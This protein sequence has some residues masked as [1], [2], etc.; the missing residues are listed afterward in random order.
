MYF[1]SDF[2]NQINNS[3]ELKSLSGTK[4]YFLEKY[5]QDSSY[6]LAYV[7]TAYFLLLMFFARFEVIQ[8]FVIWG[9]GPTFAILVFLNYFKFPFRIPK[10]VIIYFVFWLWTYPGYLSVTYVDGYFRYFRLI[11]T[12]L[13]FFFCIQ[14]VLIRTGKIKMMYQA[15]L[16][17]SLLFFLYAVFSGEFFTPPDDTQRVQVLVDNAN[18]FAYIG[19][20]G[21]SGVLFLWKGVKNFNSKI[22]LWI[23]A[24][25]FVLMIIFTASRSG[26]ITMIVLFVCWLIFCY[27]KSFL[28]HSIL[29]I[30]LIIFFVPISYYGYSYIL[31][32][33][34]LGERLSETA[35]SEG[36]GITDESRVQLYIEGFEM[37]KSNPIY[38]VGL[39]Q[40]IILSSKKAVAHSEYMELLATTGLGGL[41]LMLYFYY[42]LIKK[43]N[44]V[45]KIV[46]DS[47]VLY[48]LNLAN[49][50][51]V[52]ILV[53]G[54]FRANFLDILT[55]VQLG[56][57]AGYSNY[58][59]IKYKT[60]KEIL[61]VE[62]ESV[63]F[64][65]L[66]DA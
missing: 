17:N 30:A 45:K 34:Y 35:G 24:S 55:M 64:P 57:I 59:A 46:T 52:S 43:N 12:I 41:L 51:I 36:S 58:L 22:W 53:F 40:F 28:K 7:L 16:A 31:E 38:G 2:V 20:T 50:I 48:R 6:Y 66:K 4:Y 3:I 27:Y 65:H 61:K 62:N 29:Y 10:E 33:T 49:A 19:L 23:I 56:F 21:L 44:A 39:S 8:S 60:Y 11:F 42:I 37:F 18:G 5:Q 54:L 15:L 32:T 1:C 13:V 9:V 26:F 47:V 14:V 63:S 25:C